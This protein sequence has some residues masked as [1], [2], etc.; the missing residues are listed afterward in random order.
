[1]PDTKKLLSRKA[2]TER[3]GD[4]TPRTNS[5][6]EKPLETRFSAADMH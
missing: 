3:Y 5:R 2:V 4:K 6:W 1:M